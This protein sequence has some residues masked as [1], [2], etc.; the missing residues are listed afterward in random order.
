MAKDAEA[1]VKSCAVCATNGRP[2]K[3]TPMARIFAP[4]VVW[5]TIGL[6]FNGPYVKFGGISILVVVDY[7]SRYVIA[8]PVRS[9]SFAHTRKVL[10]DIFEKEGFPKNMK[11]DNGPPFNGD[12]YKKYCTECGI[13]AIF[14]T[15]LYPQQNGLAESCMKLVNKA[16]SAAAA[17]GTNYIEELNA[18]V[19]AYNAA[20]HS[21]TGVPPEEVMTGRKI[22]R[23]LPLIFPT[24][25]THDDDLINAKDRKSKI[26][27]KQ[28]EDA[29]RGARQC[30]IKPG[31]MV[32]VERQLRAKAESRFDPQKYTV[33]EERNGMLVLADTNGQI[34]K[35]HV[36]QTK[37]VYDWRHTEEDQPKQPDSGHTDHRDG[38][39][40]PNFQAEAPV[41]SVIDRPI[42]ERKTP[43]Y[44]KNYV[45]VVEETKE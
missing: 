10:D 3:P 25:A 26:E 1:W 13:N 17:S 34:L 14:S 36:S 30:R 44:L 8:K 33:T 32:I 43:E 27:A 28:R 45:R 16:M 2:E 15:P 38:E 35:R 23:G 12:E 7:R 40:Q 21:V 5:E 41:P 37:K 24:K 11:S 31:D 22:R 6:D 9:T 39:L 18:A 20:A 42:R 29:K 4:Q 19:H